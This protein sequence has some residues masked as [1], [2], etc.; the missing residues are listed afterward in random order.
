MDNLKLLPNRKI[1]DS[2][3]GGSVGDTANVHMLMNIGTASVLTSYYPTVMYL[4]GQRNIL[5]MYQGTKVSS[6][7]LTGASAVLVHACKEM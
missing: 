6:M 7:Q 1:W 3:G 5:G 2:G 4:P